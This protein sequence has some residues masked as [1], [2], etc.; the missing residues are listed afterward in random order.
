MKNM[1][2]CC[3]S[4]AKFYGKSIKLDMVN[5]ICFHFDIKKR[6]IGISQKV[7][8]DSRLYLAKVHEKSGI[9]GMPIISL[10]AR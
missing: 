4:K 5:L 7:N 10:T 3:L 6:K 1:Q 2:C 9:P 8:R